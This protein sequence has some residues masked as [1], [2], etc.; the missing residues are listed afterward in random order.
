[1]EE[2]ARGLDPR[3]RDSDG[4]LIPDDLDVDYQL[5]LDGDIVLV[6]DPDLPA[7]DLVAVLSGA[8]DMV[9]ATPDELVEQHD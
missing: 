8:T 1:G 2:I 5:E 6:M 4:D 3:S 7:G 9:L